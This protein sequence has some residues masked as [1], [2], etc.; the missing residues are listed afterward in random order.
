MKIMN[1]PTIFI[2]NPNTGMDD[3]FA[4]C[5][6]AEKEKWGVVVESVTKD[7]I[8]NAINK[9]ASIRPSINEFENVA[10]TIASMI[11]EDRL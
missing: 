3:Q 1:M 7:N 5:R 8:R 4:R 6:V 2:P 11:L 9:L 10:K